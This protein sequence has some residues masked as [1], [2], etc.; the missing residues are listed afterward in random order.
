MR[1]TRVTRGTGLLEGFL[2]RQRA[3]IADRLVASSHRGGCL[4]D[5]GC[6]SYPLFLSQTHFVR[7]I[8]L[9]KTAWDEAV[10][11]TVPQDLE[12]VPHDLAGDSG[13][14]LPSDLC[15]VITMLAV[16]EHLEPE[17]VLPLLRDIHRVLKPGGMLILTT[18]SA[19]VDS[20]LRVMAKLGLVSPVEIEEHKAAYTRAALRA[21]L[22]QVFPA[23]GVQLGFFE[24][25]MNMWATASK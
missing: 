14:P 13:L 3:R 9:D 17:R 6:G 5:L 24:L 10:L 4:A 8:G 22:G 25:R 20:L 11:Q 2:A 23:E 18:P 1:S 16:I 21:L 15:A 19:W 7:K 12:F